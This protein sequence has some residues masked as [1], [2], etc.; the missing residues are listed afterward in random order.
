MNTPLDVRNRL[1]RY[2]QLDPETGCWVWQRATAAGYGR[3]KF[4]GRLDLAHR[5]SWT[6]FRGEIP[7]GMTID[8]LCR[9]RAC[10]NPHHLEPVTH[11]EN[12][13]RAVPFRTPVSDDVCIRGHEP[14]WRWNGTQRVCRPCARLVK[15]R[16]RLRNEMDARLVH[17]GE[18][19]THVIEQVAS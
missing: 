13:K 6:L 7:E 5:V 11:S 3:I 10:I 9:N 2:H 15:R 8:H 19:P 12:C 14:D 16:L 18:I 17:L 4:R 1:I